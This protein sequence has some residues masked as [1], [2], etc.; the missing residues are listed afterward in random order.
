MIKY[1]IEKGALHLPLKSPYQ[2]EYTPLHFAAKCGNYYTVKTLIE[3]GANVQALNAKYE[4]PLHLAAQNSDNMDVIE[5]LVQN[6]AM[7]NPNPRQKRILSY[8]V[9]GALAYR[10]LEV[11][12]YFVED[13]DQDII[14][15]D[16]NKAEMYPPHIGNDIVKYLTEK[17][18]EKEIAKEA[19]LPRTKT[20]DMECEICCKVRTDIF[21]FVPCGHANACEKCCLKLTNPDDDDRTPTCP[22]CRVPITTYMKVFI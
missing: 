16:I 8:V 7:K 5:L 14:E 9:D 13:L 3:H 10:D 4:T 1:L 2:S 19:N 21:V 12:K 15:E 6:G 18:N 11:L 22:N 20:I 17:Q